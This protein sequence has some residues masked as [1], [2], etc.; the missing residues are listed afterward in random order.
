VGAGGKTG[1][2]GGGGLGAG[3]DIFV[4]QGGTLTVD[5]GLLNAGTVTGGAS[6]FQVGGGYGSVIFLEGVEK[7]TLSASAGH[8]LTVSGVIAD[9]NG[10]GAGGASEGYGGLTIAGTGVVTL[11]AKNT[12]TDGTR[13]VSGTLVLGAPGAAGQYGYIGFSASAGA[14][15][16]LAF[17]AANAPVNLIDNLGTGDFFDVLDKTVIGDPYTDNGDE[18]GTLKL[19]FS[20]GTS[21]SLNIVNPYGHYTQSDFQIVGGGLVTAACFA[22]GTRLATPGGFVAVENVRAGDVLTTRDGPQAAIWVG[23][24]WIDL[25][26]HAVPAEVM[27]VRVRRDAFGAGCPARDVLLSPDHAVFA[28][29]VLIP[30]KLLVNAATIVQERDVDQITYFHVELRRHGVVFADGLPS[31]SYLDT[32]NRHMFDNW[33]ASLS[34][35]LPGRGAIQDQAAQA[36]GRKRAS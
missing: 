31:E 36:G 26:G 10:S 14:D 23:R 30:V 2:S 12:Y 20:D 32:G 35:R 29:G 1:G 18:T 13:I 16:V 19:E 24:R 15:P 6:Q 5:G 3:G 34:D 25:A 17:D 22:A 28:E 7:I 11:A 21:V 27:P 33:A 8:P 9:Q 4:A